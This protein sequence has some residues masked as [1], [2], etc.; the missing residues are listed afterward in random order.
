MA[1]LWLKIAPTAAQ[2]TIASF[3]HRKKG[4]EI[5]QRPQSPEAIKENGAHNKY[6]ESIQSTAECVLVHANDIP[7][8]QSWTAKLSLWRRC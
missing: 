8:P 4:C 5:R 1:C 2:S 6:E 3:E 7:F